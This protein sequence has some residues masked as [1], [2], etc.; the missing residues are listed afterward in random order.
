MSI[1]VWTHLRKVISESLG[2]SWVSRVE[3]A[4][5]IASA[6]RFCPSVKTQGFYRPGG[7][8][9]QRINIEGIARCGPIWI[10][11]RKKIGSFLSSCLEK[12]LFTR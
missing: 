8:A 3:K 7:C 1:A 5:W 4:G 11:S 10:F 6:I 2:L 9:S 12:Y